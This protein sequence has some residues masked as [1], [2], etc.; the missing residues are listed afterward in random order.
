MLTNRYAAVSERSL[1]APGLGQ[2]PRGLL[3]VF[4]IR[5][6]GRNPGIGRRE[7]PV[8]VVATHAWT[9]GQP[10][11]FLCF[12]ACFVIGQSAPLLGNSQQC[13]SS[14]LSLVLWAARR[15]CSALLRHCSDVGIPQRSTLRSNK[16]SRLTR[17]K[18]GNGVPRHWGIPQAYGTRKNHALS[19]FV[20]PIRRRQR[21]QVRCHN[22]GAIVAVAAAIL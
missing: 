8:G 6:A 4:E 10:L 21:C 13:L 22:A 17:H 18:S 12:L 5:G 1:D 3:P 11:G 15:H 16:K 2:K 19:P 14:S 20:S 9:P 7:G